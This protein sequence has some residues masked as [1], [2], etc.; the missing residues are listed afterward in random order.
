MKDIHKVIGERIKALRLRENM[1][2]EEL[3][4][5][6]NLH[7][8]YVGILERGERNPSLKSLVKIAA[9][10]N[11]NPDYFLDTGKRIRLPNPVPAHYFE[12]RDMLADKSE[13]DVKFALS[14]LKQILNKLE[15]KGRAKS[16][17]KR[18]KQERKPVEK[19]SP[20]VTGK[21]RRKSHGSIL[22]GSGSLNEEK[23]FPGRKSILS[24]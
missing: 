20:K 3:A 4:E 8:S 13:D 10:F 23:G 21:R 24:R 19:V 14:L 18:K 1:T 16:R 2:Q 22:I 9:V 6:V 12:I 7:P 11:I 17:A 15:G 5:K